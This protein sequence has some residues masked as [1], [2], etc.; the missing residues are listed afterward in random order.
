MKHPEPKTLIFD[1]E[2]SLDILASYGLREQYHSPNNILQDWYFIC[3]GWKWLGGKRIYDYSILDDAKRF[4]KCFHDDY[5]VIKRLHELL[6]DVDIIIGHNMARFDWR[7]FMARVIYHR[8]PPIPKPAI[9]DTLKEARKIAAFT[10]NRMDYLASHLGVE[11]KLHHAGD[12]W[13]RVLRGDAKAIQE[14]VTYCRGDIATTEALYLR[15][16]PYMETHPNFAL[17]RADGIEACEKCGSEDIQSRGTRITKTRRYRRYQCQC[18]GAWSNGTV[19]IAK[20]VI[21]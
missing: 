5:A 14:A 16:R 20:A 8:L 4:K 9:I 21:K 7:K 19:A 12:M 2:T 11:N 1:V 13:L 15:L 18:C 3:F 10:S 17:W 6:S